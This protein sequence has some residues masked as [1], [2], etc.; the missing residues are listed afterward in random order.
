[1]AYLSENRIGCAIHYPVPVH[2]QRG[3]AER[4]VGSPGRLPVTERV[5]QQI[6]SL[7]IY[8]ELSDADVERV[9]ATVR[10]FFA[11]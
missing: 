9:I 11:R 8:P 4:V 6:L 5:C 2:N 1:M 7:P 3:Y 10:S